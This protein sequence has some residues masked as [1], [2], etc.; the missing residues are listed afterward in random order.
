MTGA[1]DDEVDTA[2]ELDRRDQMTPTDE[3]EF[4]S[5]LPG[6]RPVEADVPPDKPESDV[7][8][9]SQPVGTDDDY[10]DE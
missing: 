10:D 3:D 7:L 4:D 1:Y 8:E 6:G 5:R 2:D 9:Q